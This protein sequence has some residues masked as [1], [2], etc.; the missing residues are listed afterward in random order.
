MVVFFVFLTFLYNCDILYLGDNMNDI[1]N[2]ILSIGA[3][4]FLGLVASFSVLLGSYKK[5][6]WEVINAK[7]NKFND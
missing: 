1:I 2:L 4:V 7:D 3:T 6:I 5:E